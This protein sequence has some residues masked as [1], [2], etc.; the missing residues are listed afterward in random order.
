[1]EEK[2]G[3]K[4]KERFNKILIKIFILLPIFSAL[5][6]LIFAQTASATGCC[7][8]PEDG[9]CSLNSDEN[10]CSS[11][12]GEFYET[13]PAEKCSKGCCIL[14]INTAYVTER[15]CEVESRTF[16]FEKKFQGGDEESCIEIASNQETGACVTE[17]GYDKICKFVT[18]EKCSDDFYPDVL[19]TDP[20][21]NTLCKKTAG[22]MCY[23]GDVYAV[24]SCE[25]PDEKK[26]DCDYNKGTVCAKASIGGSYI[27]KEI[28]CKLG[29]ET[30]LNGE[31]WCK[32]EDAN[33]VGSRY[34]RQYCLNGEIIT[35]PCADFRMESCEEG[36]C[37][38]NPWQTC[39]AANL[40][41]PDPITGSKVD[42][43]LC[44]EE[45]CTI[46][47]PVEKEGGETSCFLYEDDRVYC[48]VGGKT[49]YSY[50]DGWREKTPPSGSKTPYSMNTDIPISGENYE[51]KMMQDLHLE[52]CLPKI[53]A[54]LAFYPQTGSSGPGT[55]AQTTCALGNYN[56]KIEFINIGDDWY[57]RLDKGMR[58]YFGSSGL[59]DAK[60]NQWGDYTDSDQELTCIGGNEYC[61]EASTIRGPTI[62][63]NP[64]VIQLLNQ[65]CT[66]IGDCDGKVNWI[67][68]SGTPG[69]ELSKIPLTSATGYNTE[70]TF[71]FQCKPWIVPSGSSSCARCGADNLPCSEY[72]CK[73]LGK[74]DYFE[75]AGA[76]KG[77]CVPAKD[78][79]SPK[80]I[81]TINPASPVPPYTSVEINITTNEVSKCKFDIGSSGS[82]ISEMKFDLGGNWGLEHS[83]ILS[84]P[85]QK[86]GIKNQ[87][88]YDLIK[89]G[90]VYDMYV[91][92]EDAAGNFNIAAELIRFEV[93]P[94]P[95]KLAPYIMSFE[96]ASGARIKSNTTSKEIKFRL[97]EPVECKWSFKDRVFSEMENNFSCD[98][99]IS[100]YG[101]L[102][103]YWCSGKL[104]NITKDITKETK[105]YIRCKDQPWLE[106][107]E[108]ELYSRNKN[109]KSREYVLKASEP[110]KITD[111]TPKGNIK[112]TGG[113]SSVEIK[114]L[115]SNG[116]ANGM[117][118][119]RWKLSSNSAN[120]S[121][122]FD[123]FKNTNSTIHTQRTSNLTE[124][125][126]KI[127][128]R[129]AD[130]SENE[131]NATSEFKLEIDKSSPRII[132]VYNS[133]GRLKVITDEEAECKFTSDSK[134]KCSFAFDNSNITLMQGAGK[135]HT[136]DWINGKDYY[137]RCRD[138]Y[139]NENAGCGIIVRTY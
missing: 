82:K 18:R 1:M 22:T 8:T 70:Y 41:K 55:T 109:D 69:T 119:C 131:A 76:D 81:Y 56:S 38:I 7:F 72:R 45:Y 113:E 106:G 120:L 19:C 74:C 99:A 9:F 66:A 92:C 54:G 47:N 44:D 61:L 135:E 103:G 13:C 35:E 14:G 24:D 73:S 32:S 52:M 53:A 91:R 23:N 95:D 126:Y 10:A 49:Y 28:N 57:F 116:G 123:F 97:N 43:E 17:S 65:R 124:G 46:F 62:S 127:E 68:K 96:P 93:M 94:T 37:V 84:L 122:V 125:S 48:E 29:N 4:L 6:A 137:I 16:G 67:G 36:K 77:Y 71:D 115:T 129:C 26:Y 111:L 40:A 83:I 3:K 136:A 130:K 138:Y 31:K 118:T 80:L 121:N 60:A 100:D 90:G 27:C 51:M 39:L 105:Y 11:L 102:N 108:S 78:F 12:S 112:K 117:A 132:R 42:V 58:D 21:L 98:T 139:E 104:T 107:Q 110:L 34:F 134:L 128:V 33:K 88:R 50:E 59:I 133:G 114:A 15:T 5:I 2:R 79:N 25:N 63:A 85:G 87:S 75:P 89:D 86:L 30:K 64:K 20:S 101:M